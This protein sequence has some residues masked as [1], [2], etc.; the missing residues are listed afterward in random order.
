MMFTT[1]LTKF[2]LLSFTLGSIVQS[3]P[4]RVEKRIAQVIADSTAKWEKA[5]LAAGGAD[6]CNPVS[7]AAFTTLLAAAGPCEQQDSGDAMIDLAKTLNNDPEMIRLTQIFVQQPRNSPNSVA[8]PYCQQAPKNAELNGLFQCQFQGSNQQKF[9]NGAQAGG[10]GT[11]PFGQNAPLNPAGSCPANADGPIADGTQLSDLVQDPGAGDAGSG[12]GSGEDPTRSTP[13]ASGGTSATTSAASP[14]AQTSIASTGPGTDVNN[15]AGSGNGGETTTV[16][17]PAPPAQTSA[18]DSSMGTTTGTAG[19]AGGDFKKQ[20]G[21]DAQQEN[22]KFATLTADTSCTEGEN[23]CVQG[24]FAQC[25]GGTFAIQPCSGGLQCFSLPLVNKAGTSIACT[26][27]DDAAARIAA[28]GATGGISGDGSTSTSTEPTS[29]GSSGTATPPSSDEPSGTATPSPSD[30][31]ADTTADPSSDESS[32]GVGPSTDSDDCEDTSID[33]SSNAGD[34]TGMSTGSASAGS[35]MTNAS[36][37]TATGG[38]SNVQLGNG[39]DA[40]KLN[41][42]FATLTESSTCTD[43]ESA[44]IKDSFAQCV[45]GKFALQPCGSGLTCVA[46]PLV[47]SKGTSVTCTTTTDAEARIKASGA[48]GGVTGA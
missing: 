18:S 23:A 33:D 17:S 25:V 47:N 7:V 36:S 45:G 46:L 30:G 15:G 11:I 5:C 43:G 34:N 19:S 48:T 44:C 13:A 21:I 31:S 20:N 41:A 4:I 39:Q 12:A 38:T 35:A 1:K 2:I 10:D 42:K 27:Q 28:S 8:I 3:V 24:G 40:Q 14:P 37:D 26:T 6:K 22:A 16:S 32:T 29:D 9:A